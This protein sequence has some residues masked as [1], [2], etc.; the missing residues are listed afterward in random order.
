MKNVHLLIIDPQF[1]FC[2]PNGALYVPGAE[3]DMDRLTTMIDRIGDKLA[4]IHVTLDSH[5]LMD[6]AHPAWWKDSSGN[7]PAPFTIITASDVKDGIWT[8]VL[9]HL[10]KRMIDYTEQLEVNGRYPLCIWPPH[11][12]IGSKGH[13][14]HEGLFKVLCQWEQD[15]HAVVDFVSKGSNVYTEHYSAVQADVPDATDPSTQINTPL[16]QTLQDGDIIVVAGEAGTHCLAN[17]ATDIANAFGDDSHVQKLVL[18]ED[19]T[20]PVPGFEQMYED[21]KN[22]MVPRGMQISNTA[23]FLS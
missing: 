15:N 11:C 23:N 9:P 19:A 10:T 8:P 1:D 2:D 6:V 16:I 13:S 4:D 22:V 7:N 21:F 14:V 3:K 18:L 5:H 12:L 17:T 20:S